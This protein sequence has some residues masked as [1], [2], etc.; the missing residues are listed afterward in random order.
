[1]KYHYLLQYQLK[2]W[3][4]KVAGGRFCTIVNMA[5]KISALLS[6]LGSV[7]DLYYGFQ[8]EAGRFEI[9]GGM[10]LLN[11]L[12]KFLDEFLG[13]VS[14]G[15]LSKLF[16]LFLSKTTSAIISENKASVDSRTTPAFK[17]EL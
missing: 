9:S 6:I 11:P 12:L 1:V 14:A 10:F 3:N 16:L 4:H 8:L 17:Q 2:L 7:L 5:D 15:G 13:F